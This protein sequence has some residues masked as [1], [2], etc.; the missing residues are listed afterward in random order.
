MSDEIKAPI[1]VIN[2]R[3]K[4]FADVSQH[5]F[6][7][8]RDRCKAE[9]ITIGEALAELVHQYAHG[10]VLIPGTKKPHHDAGVDYL[11]ERE[12]T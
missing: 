11:K 3:R 5:D 6:D 12:V 9:G 1:S 7:S 8:F 10:A 4:V 2:S